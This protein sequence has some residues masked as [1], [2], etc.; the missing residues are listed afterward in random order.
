LLRHYATSRKVAGSIP[1][2]VTGFFLNLRNPS[3]R[4]NLG[5]DSASN[6]NEYQEPS[7]GVKSGKR[8]RLTTS[9]PCV[10]RLPRKCGSL[11]ASQSYGPP[12]PVRGLALLYCLL[13]GVMSRKT[14]LFLT[15]AVRTSNTTDYEA[16][17]DLTI[18]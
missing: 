3:S 6:R 8:V 15:T 7:L 4:T 5:V 16:P 18:F 10:S 11:D 12:W 1:D 14:E 17:Q 13:H 2:E 9:P